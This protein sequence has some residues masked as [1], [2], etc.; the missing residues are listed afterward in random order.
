MEI[1]REVKVD[2]ANQQIYISIEIN[3]NKYLD[4][5]VYSPGEDPGLDNSNIAIIAYK[6]THGIR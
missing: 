6:W 1:P 5:T 4:R 3:K 2:L